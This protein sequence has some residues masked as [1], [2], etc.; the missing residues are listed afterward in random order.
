MSRL[1]AESANGTRVPLASSMGLMER[2]TGGEDGVASWST[3]GDIEIGVAARV[4]MG[5]VL[6]VEM[7][8]LR[9]LI[10]RIHSWLV[11]SILILKSSV[12]NAYRTLAL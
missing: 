3:L 7:Q 5:I 9:W 12:F 8:S 6:V 11:S 4:W 2:R 1:L 10:V